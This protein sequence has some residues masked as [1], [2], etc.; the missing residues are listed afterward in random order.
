M[1]LYYVHDPMCSW[2][3]AFHPVWQEIQSKLSVDIAVEYLLG[4]LAPDSE[5]SMSPVTQREIQAHWK[6]IRKQVP[7]IMFNFDFWKLNTP[8]RSTYPACRAVIA[9]KRQD[10]LIESA[11]I[12]AIQTAYYLEARNPSDSDVLIACAKNV[13]LDSEQFEAD[14]L[15]TATQTQLMN[16]IRQAQRMQVFS[17]PSLVVKHQ[18]KIRIIRIDYND[19]EVVLTQIRSISDSFNR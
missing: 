17:F 13:G 15:A 3:W 2:C 12:H 6:T 11:M 18:E 16:E 5:T 14:F 8:R 19:A 1:K 9:A 7:G 4:G 10:P